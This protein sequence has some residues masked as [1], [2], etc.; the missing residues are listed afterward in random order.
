[1]EKETEEQQALIVLFSWGWIQCNYQLRGPAS[2]DSLPWCSIACERGQ[3]DPFSLK[4]LSW[5]YFITASGKETKTYG[6]KW[7]CLRV[8]ISAQ[9]NMTKKQVGEERVIQ[10]TLP[11]CCWSPK[12]VRLEL[13]QGRN[14]EAGADAEGMEGC[15]LLDCFSWL[16][17]LAF[18]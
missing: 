5:K 11:H 16:A 6:T 4:L 10:L 12:E 9:S 3:T 8:S 2:A 13:K 15:Y 7:A 14:W 18:L 17:Q 1:M